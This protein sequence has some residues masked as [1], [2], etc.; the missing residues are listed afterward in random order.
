MQ[1]LKITTSSKSSIRIEVQFVDV[2]DFLQN[3]FVKTDFQ[4]RQDQI[5][6]EHLVPLPENLPWFY[7]EKQAT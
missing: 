5:F 1:F 4:K 6:E 7:S 3:N 2:I